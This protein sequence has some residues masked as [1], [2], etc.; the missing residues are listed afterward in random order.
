MFQVP[1]NVNR[2]LAEN[3]WTETKLDGY[4]TAHDALCSQQT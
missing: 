2:D 3:V 1:V 4:A